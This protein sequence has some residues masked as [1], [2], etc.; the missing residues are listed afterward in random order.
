MLSGHNN[1]AAALYNYQ[2][3]GRKYGPRLVLL[4]ITVGNDITPR[5]YKKSLWPDHDPS[6]DP[7]FK[8]IASDRRAQQ[9]DWKDLY[10]PQQAYSEPAPVRDFLLDIE[11]T[12]RKTLSEELPGFGHVVPPVI[13]R[14]PNERFSVRAGGNLTSL[15][16]FYQPL[17]PEV[18][19][20]Y[21][22]LEE[23]I[24]AMDQQVVSNGGKLL[25]VLFPT[26]AQVDSRDWQ[27][28]ERSYSLDRTRFRLDYPGTRLGQFCRANAID[29]LD[30][31]PEFEAFVQREGARLYMKRGD[32]HFN[33]AGQALT[34]DVIFDHI[35][36]SSDPMRTR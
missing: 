5:S 4:G 12:I 18:A 31:M 26:R 29:C 25:V 24:L 36:S 22:D 6:V 8:L 14:P 13:G 23:V 20:W 33:E 27:L 3:H 10:L 35:C 1:P 11:H 9:S 2:E 15:G 34:S 32:M 30:L 17:V 21:R 16:L 19:E 7:A 28:L